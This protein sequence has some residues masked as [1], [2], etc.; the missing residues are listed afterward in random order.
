[1]PVN[2]RNR[3][4]RA[5]LCLL[6]L[7]TF[8]S[9]A[10]A[11]TTNA[12]LVGDVTDSQA[13]AVAGATVTVKNTATGVAR[14]VQTSELGTYRVFPLNPGTYDVTA[15]MAGFKNKNISNVVVEVAANVKVDFQLE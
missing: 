15:S 9:I 3:S 2:T 13:G 8:S 10:L 6:V 11:Q 7:A 4:T 12:T 14:T 1:M 5:V